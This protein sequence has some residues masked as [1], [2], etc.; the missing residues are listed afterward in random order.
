MHAGPA[1]LYALAIPLEVPTNVMFFP[2]E[3]GHFTAFDPASGAV[4]RL[5]VKREGSLVIDLEGGR[6]A[7]ARRE[8][9]R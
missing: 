2:Q 1:Y 5:Q 9:G 6:R 7:S 8:K 4:T 3:G